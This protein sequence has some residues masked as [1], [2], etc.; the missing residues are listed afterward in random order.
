MATK[1]TTF[2]IGLAA[3]AAAGA[4][5]G[6]LMAPKKGADLRQDIQDKVDDLSDRVKHL[7]NRAKRRMDHIQDEI[8]DMHPHA[9]VKAGV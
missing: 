5:L 6:L 9:S 1:N 7:T 4:V 8:S 2:L 3:A